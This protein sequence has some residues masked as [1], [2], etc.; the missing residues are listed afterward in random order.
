MRP[1]EGSRI[2]DGVDKLE[3][4]PKCRDA[5]KGTGKGL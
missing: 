1:L 5:M 3:T 4:M 2:R